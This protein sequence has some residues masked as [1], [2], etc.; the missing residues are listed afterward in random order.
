MESLTLD[1]KGMT[2]MG[3]VNSVK[4]VLQD[5]PGVQA[6]DVTLESGQVR[7]VYDAGQVEPARFKSAI[8]D[9]GFDVVS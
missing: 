4:R 1:V 5:L 9:A 7:L 2:C 3:C 6:V 8:E